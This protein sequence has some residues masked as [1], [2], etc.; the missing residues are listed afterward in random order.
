MLHEKFV[1]LS[2]GNITGYELGT[3]GLISGWDFFFATMPRVALGP[4]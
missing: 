1:I 3:W 4:I 2:V